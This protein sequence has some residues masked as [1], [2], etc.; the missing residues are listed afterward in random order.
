MI[1]V[2]HYVRQSGFRNSIF[3]GINS[4][5]ACFSWSDFGK[6]SVQVYGVPGAYV[7]LFAESISLVLFVWVV[8][9]LC[10]YS[11]QSY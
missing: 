4:C 11:M 3:S 10:V 9:Y 2:V 1:Y 7:V 6:C 8:L 5:S